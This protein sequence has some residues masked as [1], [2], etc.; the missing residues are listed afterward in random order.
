VNGPVAS[1][2][3]TWFA[4]IGVLW[5]GYF[6]LEGFDFGVG[7][8]NVLI[9]RDDVDRRLA[10]N[11]IGPVWDGNEVWLIVAGGA[12]FAAFPVWYAS[13]FSGFYL[14]LFLVL[15]ALIVRGVS[16]EFRNRRE[17]RRWQHGWDWA[18]AIGSLVPS[19]IWGVAF[20]DL[21]HGLRLSPAGL[22]V[23]GFSGLLSPVAIV[24]GLAS[25]AMF[26]AH[27]ATFLSLKTAGP[28]ADRAR[29]VAMWVSPLAGALVVGT[30]ISLA[31]TGSHGAGYLGGAVPIVLA[32]VCGLAFGASGILVR[33]GRDGLAFALSAFGIV[34]VSCAIF[35]GLFPRVMVS[36]GPGPSLTIW[37]AA[38][39]N[40][41]LIVMTIVAAIFVPLVLAYQGW[42]YWVFRQRL[43]RPAGPPAASV[44]PPRAPSTPAPAPWR[45]Q[46]ASPRHRR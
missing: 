39:A 34:S 32:A 1:L 14:A 26:L 10:R 21:V 36:S 15:V 28:L 22:Y 29:L 42:S 23:G 20:T 40:R 7:M 9:G 2:N 19:F 25:L 6:V 11:A 24:G 33:F 18:M 46:A 35:T 17:S 12:T 41:T 30:A 3:T 4:L 27:G 44:P 5:T 37:N 8:L 43:I 31:V 45:A 38:S 16:F 13:M